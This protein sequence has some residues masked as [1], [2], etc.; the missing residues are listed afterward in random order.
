MFTVQSVESVEVEVLLCTVQSLECGVGGIFEG[1]LCTVQSVESVEV[2]VLLCTV[3]SLE[4]G[5]GGICEGRLCTVQSLESVEL[6]RYV[7]VTCVLYM[8]GECGV[9]GICGVNLCTVQSVESVEVEVILCTVQ[10]LECGVGGI[11]EGRLCTVQSLESVE[12]DRYVE[13]TCVL[14]MT[15]DTSPAWS[16][17]S[18]GAS[19]PRKVTAST[20]KSGRLICCQKLNQTREKSAKPFYLKLVILSFFLHDS[21]STSVSLI[22]V[23]PYKI[24][25]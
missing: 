23:G 1:R 6:D 7:E 21:K 15:G 8:T 25:Q 12:L 2:D 17:Y 3:Q 24:L 19:W 10:S 22:K 20:D 16:L 13:V 14:Y 11:C 18:P 5:V 4:C 9:G